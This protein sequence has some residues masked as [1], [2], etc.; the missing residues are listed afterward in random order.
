MEKYKDKGLT[1]LANLGNTCFINSTLQ[2]LS[3][4]YE[5]N[6]FLE[7]KRYKLNI[8]KNKYDCLILKE[9]NDLR[10]LMWS[11]NCKINP[12]GF[13]VNVH[14]VAEQKGRM[15]FTG[16]TQN[17]LPEFLLFL[18]DSFHESIKR[19]VNIKIEGRVLNESDKIAKKC[20]EMMK[21]MYE[22][23]YSEILRMFYGIHVSR[24]K[25]LNGKILSEKPEPYFLVSLPIPEKNKSPSIYDCFNEYSKN[26]RLEGENKWYDEETKEKKEVDKSI[27]FFSLPEIL[28]IDFKRFNNSLRKNQVLIDYPLEDLDLSKYVIGYNKEDYKYDLYGICNH[29]GSVMGGHYTSYVKNENGKWYHFNDL[30]VSEIVK[31][32]LVSPKAYCLFYRKKNRK[33]KI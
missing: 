27:E 10:E 4:S 3:H 2:C 12:K 14:K 33:D 5:L 30:S 32:K 23:E 15:I 1:G 28:V 19:S 18:I 21:N 26:E 29:S 25:D 11:E 24:I 7:S 31:E 9:W 17:D 20:Y 22:K 6:E 8:E 16:Y 13:I